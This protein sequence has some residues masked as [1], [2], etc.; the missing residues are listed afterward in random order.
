MAATT[1]GIGEAG[2]SFTGDLMVSGGVTP[3]TVSITKG[4]LPAG[5]SLGNDGII[6]GTLSSNAKSGKI[7]VR[8]TDSVNESITQTF[9]INVVKALSVSG[10]VKTGRMGKNYNASF[11]IKG[12]QSPFTWSITSGALPMGLSFNTATGAIAGMPTESGVFPL[13]A[14]VADALGGVA[15]VNQTLKIN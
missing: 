13:T 5:L 6:S 3:Y 7:T 10:K 9:T 1:L 8:I 4:A 11:K 2:V 12:G 14:Q 15:A